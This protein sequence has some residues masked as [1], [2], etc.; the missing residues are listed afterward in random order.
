VVL[1]ELER[2]VGGEAADGHHELEARQQAHDERGVAAGDVEQRRG[3]QRHRLGRRGG[4][5]AATGTAEEVRSEHGARHRAEHRVLEVGDHA[6]VGRHRSLGAAGG[7]R[8]VEDDRRVLL[9]DGRVDEGGG[10]LL[11]EL[12]EAVQLPGLGRFGEVLGRG[13]DQED[14]LEVGRRVERAGDA[15]EALAVGHEDPGTGVLQPVLDLVGLPPAVEADEDGPT[16]DR[17]PEG[18]APLGVVLRQDG[19]PVPV[20]QAVAVLPGVGDAV[21]RLDEGLEAV[22]AVPVDDEGLRIAP[23]DGQLGDL[24]QRRQA[25]LVDLERPAVDLLGVDL[26]HPAGTGE[27][28]AD[29]RCGGHGR[30]T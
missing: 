23:H 1:D 9:V 25:V 29:L 3:E 22:G 10:G 30:A 12:V 17:R 28:L 18:E 16:G 13:V 4:R 8:G 15:L 21:R 6:A 26:E 11:R 5:V 7:A 24:P 2:L 20:A 27:L 14:V 19:D